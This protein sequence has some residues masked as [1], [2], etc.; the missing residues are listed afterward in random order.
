[1]RRSGQSGRGRLWCEPADRANCV[2]FAVVSTDHCGQRRGR[3]EPNSS[4]IRLQ[5]MAE[6]GPEIAADVVAACQAGA[7]EA[8][9]AFSRALDAAVKLE[10]GA[11][12]TLDRTA[13]PDAIAGPGLAVLLKIG[14]RGA[15]VLI[16]ESTGLLPGWYA[17]P[18]P[19][20]QSKLTTLAQE[21][22]MLLVPEALMPDD[23]QAA[24]VSDLR[25]CLERSGVASGAGWVPLTLAG[26]SANGVAHLI[27]PVALPGAV[28]QESA[29]ATTTSEPVVAA[30]PAVAVEPRPAPQAAKIPPVG[31]R[32]IAR[33]DELPAYTRSLLKI[34]VPIVVTLAATTLPVQRI[35]ELV[36]GTIIQ[37]EKSCEDMLELNAG[38]CPVA[39]GEAV[40]IGEKFGLR[41]TS[42]ILPDERFGPVRS[43]SAARR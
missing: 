43:K 17:A 2:K 11:S 29:A 39:E 24:K 7:S 42:L 14:D 15:L 27:W 8:S 18:D 9:E 19:T 35:V 40:K 41:V 5:T 33:P 22:G 3:S 25:A 16:A 20:G 31:P 32:K 6:F 4:T 30:A 10:V 1:M 36:P 12:G 37:F 23:F 13:W 28:Y 21:L 38:N 34:R 26:A